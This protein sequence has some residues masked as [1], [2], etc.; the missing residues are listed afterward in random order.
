MWKHKCGRDKNT[1]VT[2]S[3]KTTF[4]QQGQMSPKKKLT[5]F[6]C[7]SWW[8]D[9]GMQLFSKHDVFKHFLMK[10]NICTLISINITGYS[11]WFLCSDSGTG[12]LPLLQTQLTPARMQGEL[13]TSFTLQYSTHTEYF[14]SLATQISLGKQSLCFCVVQ[15]SEDILSLPE[16]S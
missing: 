4:D 12:T 16:V 15:L 7:L 3:L 5:A 10:I 1:F 2:A 13:T 8:G 14:V 6:C 9:Q 11:C